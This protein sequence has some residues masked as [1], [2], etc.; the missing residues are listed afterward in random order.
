MVRQEL[1]LRDIC[2]GSQ[3]VG[4]GSAGGYWGKAHSAS[5]VD[6]EY[7]TWPLQASSYSGLGRGGKMEPTSTFIPGAISCRS[8]PL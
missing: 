6:G 4:C 7:K 3:V 8:L 5:K 2:R 1:L